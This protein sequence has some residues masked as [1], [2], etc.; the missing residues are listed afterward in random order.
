MDIVVML[1]IGLGLA[2]DVFAIAVS[3]GSVLGR[4]KASGIVL[5][6]LMVCAWQLAAMTIGVGIAS[7]VGVQNLSREVRMV[8]KILAGII[9]T[10]LG[11]VK[12]LLI[13]HRKAVPEV[14]S[15][16]DFKKTCGIASST[17]IY[18]L[19]AG[20]ACELLE[21]DTVSVAVMICVLTVAIVLIGVFVGYRNGEL[22]K[23]VYWSGG[24][25]LIMVGI[26]TMAN[27]IGLNIF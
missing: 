13:Y 14:R 23:R 1:L 16:I 26:L 3:Q 11:A 5:L 25:L 10:G 12:L 9:L 17:S 27:S 22:D 6:C 19:F 21:F 18:T 24:I 15:D 20:F 4:V 8:W 2:F 7:I